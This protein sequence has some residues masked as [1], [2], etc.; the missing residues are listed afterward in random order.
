MDDDGRRLSKNTA[1][2]SASTQYEGG[3]AA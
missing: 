2:E 1:V 3:M